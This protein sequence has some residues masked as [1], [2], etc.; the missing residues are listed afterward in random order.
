M[1][2]DELRSRCME[3]PEL[4]QLLAQLNQEP[5]IETVKRRLK[6][7]QRAKRR[8]KISRIIM[9]ASAAVLLGLAVIPL[10]PGHS[11]EAPLQKAAFMLE[12]AALWGLQRVDKEGEKYEVPK[13]WL[14]VREFLQDEH[15]RIGQNIRLDQWSSA[16]VCIAIACVG[17]YASPFLS[18]GLRIAC[19]A[20]TAAVV[21]AF[22]IYDHRKIAHLKRSRDDI[23]ADLDYLLRD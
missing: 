22:F 14:N 15:H 12:M 11:R 23:A 18:R 16:L 5:P 7:E 17:L 8:R 9:K 1:D 3:D 6:M 13:V 4:E 20:V 21:L 10:F 19:L 2:F